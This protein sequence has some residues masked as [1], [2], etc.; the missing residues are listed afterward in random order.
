VSVSSSN[1][2]EVHVAIEE[3]PCVERYRNQLDVDPTNG[4]LWC[5]LGFLLRQL[6]RDDEAI[7][8]FRQAITY[9]PNNESAWKHLALLYE[10]KGN[11]LDASRA[12]KAVEALRAERYS[13][14]MQMAPW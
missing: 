1:P 2:F 12:W 10:S 14:Q 4:R 9:K 7:E 13:L 3:D 8:A 6:G 11:L 5:Q